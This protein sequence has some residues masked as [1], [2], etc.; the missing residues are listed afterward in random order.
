MSIESLAI[1]LIALAAGAVVKGITGLGL[2]LV[3]MPVL[4][5]FIGVQHAVAVMVFPG[6]ASNTLLIHRQWAHAR[7]MPELPALMISGVIGAVIGT[8]GLSSLDERLL[9]IA[10][11]A[12]IALYLVLMVARPHARISPRV[13][14]VLTPIVGLFAGL[15]QGATGIS[16]PIIGTY[17]VAF[18]LEP[19][20][21]VFAAA[22][23]FQA[24][25]M[26]QLFAL[27]WFGIIDLERAIEGLIAV[28]PILIVVPLAARYTSRFSRRKF[29]LGLAA[30][31]VVL[32]GRLALKGI[33]GV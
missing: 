17:L 29:E 7:A 14:R 9:S 10:I 30:V 4:A 5:N 11:A 27:I 21:Y 2:P 33:W 25:A 19:A 26:V 16:G 8:W 32:G 6:L 24:M 1:I 13:S 3:A 22:S 20:A 15:V 28:I 18:R 31:L 12:M 23:T